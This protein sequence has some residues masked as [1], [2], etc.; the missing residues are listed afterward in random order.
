MSFIT[1]PWCDNP[2]N[3]S[4]LLKAGLLK[5]GQTT[6]YHANDDGDLEKGIAKDFTV[7][8]AGRYSGTTNI[9]INGKT[10]AMS[11]A[12]IKDNNTGLMWAREVP[13]SDIGAG[14]DG[15]L[16]WDAWSLADKITISFDNASSE[17]RDSA[18]GFDT[19]ALC[20]GRKLTVTGST[21]NDGTYTV[22]GIAAGVITVSEAIADELAGAT[23]TIETT[24]DLIWDLADQANANSLGG[25]SDWGIPNLNQLYSIVNL[26]E[27]N[28]CIDTTIFPSTPG[29]NCWTSSGRVLYTDRIYY[30]QF[31]WGNVGYGIATN[32]KYYTHL[33][34][35]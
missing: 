5:T 4:S 3:Y 34:R 21:S 22:T 2:W 26:N 6:S 8:T 15:K 35:G 10:L 19:G 13:Q 20:V 33:V 28:P 27:Y 16:F 7:L 14:A 18:S 12:C 17:I 25:Y 30:V 31:L 11:N 32:V 1:N 24:G 9:V 29:T 23:V